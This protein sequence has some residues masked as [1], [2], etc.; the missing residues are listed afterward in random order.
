MEVNELKNATILVVDDN[1]INLNVLSDSLTEHGFTILLKKDGEKA[2][3]L[4]KRKKPD[5]ILLDIVMPGI[6]GFETCKRLKDDEETKDIPVIF[7]TALSDTIDKLKGFKLGAVDYI[8]KPFHQEEVLARVKTHL[9]IQ[10]LK[11]DL[12]VK[13]KKLQNSLE[14]ERKLIEDLRLNLSLSLPHE[15]RTPLNGI[16]GFSE[17]LTDPVRLP[18]PDKIIKYGKAINESGQ[19]LHR[20]VENALLYANLKLLK[21]AATDRR[22][23]Q[24]DSS[25][26]AKDFIVSVARRRAKEVRRENDLALELNDANILIST[27]NFDKILSEIIGNAFKFSQGGSPVRVKTT[28]NGSLC[29]LSISDQ[30]YGMTK[31]QIDNI[32]AYM[33]FDRERHEQQGS[34]LGLIISYLLAQLEGGMLSI[35]SAADRGTTVTIVLNHEPAEVEKNNANWFEPDIYDIVGE[36]DIAGYVP[37]EPVEKDKYKVLVIDEKKGNFSVFDK[38]LTPVGFELIKTANGYDGLNRV[39]ESLP[40]IIFIDMFMLEAGVDVITKLRQSEGSEQVKLIAVSFGTLDAAQEEILTPLCDDVIPTPVQPQ[41][42]CD[43]LEIHL[44]LEWIYKEEKE[45][46]LP[47]QADLKKIHNMAV[48]GQMHNIIEELNKIEQ[49]G[50]Q[51]IPFVT[52]LRRF[53][54]VFQVKLIRRFL[55]KHSAL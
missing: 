36:P 45:M 50:E 24:S 30:G 40:D 1:P 21:Y 52:K 17:F 51:Y 55:E 14:R 19:R 29:V 48:H 49:V 33:Q 38:L 41:D 7:M 37:V 32:G 31:E 46:V 26:G 15:L 42:I 11:K 2:L 18:K 22:I 3:S 23:L 34:G 35:D 28:V 16:L 25:V 39:L 54:D 6:D 47:P 53:A 10:K 12:Q 13:N 20:L 5:I 9:T 43:T 27:K 8:T 4:V 44:E